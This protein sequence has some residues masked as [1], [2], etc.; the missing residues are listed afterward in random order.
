MRLALMSCGGS[1]G[2]S[3][4]AMMAVRANPTMGGAEGADERRVFLVNWLKPRF[5]MAT[6]IAL[7]TVGVSIDFRRL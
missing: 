6:S 1:E 5:P 4:P 7:H 3:F 2:A